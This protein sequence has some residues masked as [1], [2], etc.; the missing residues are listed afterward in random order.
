MGPH[1]ALGE[2]PYPIVVAGPHTGGTVVTPH[3]TVGG[4]ALTAHPLVGGNQNPPTTAATPKKDSYT[5]L[6]LSLTWA[7]IKVAST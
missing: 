5:K 3:R 7:G 6:E 4:T 1:T 2:P